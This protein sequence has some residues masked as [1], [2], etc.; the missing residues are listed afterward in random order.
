MSEYHKIDSVFKRDPET[1]HNGHP[2]REAEPRGVDGQRASVRTSPLP[3][4]A[5]RRARES[6]TY[7]ATCP[8]GRSSRGSASWR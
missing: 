2:A 1:K 7:Q 5:P 4:S 3:S 6:G 8:P